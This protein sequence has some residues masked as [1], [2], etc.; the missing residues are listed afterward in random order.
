MRETIIETEA[1][2]R[3]DSAVD[4]VMDAERGF[5][6]FVLAYGQAGRGKS[7][8]ADRYHYTRGGAYVRVWQG[9]SQTAFLQRLLFEVRGTNEDMPRHTGNRCK[10]LIVKLL[11]KKR[12]PLFIDEADRLQIARIEDLRDI[13]EAT[14]VPVV[15]IGEEGIFGLL[16][17]R[18]RIWSRVAHEV[19]FGPIS[20]AEVALYAMQAAGLEIPLALSKEIAQKTEGDFRLVRNAMILLEKSAKASGSFSVDQKMLDAALSAHSWRRK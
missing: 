7:V 4:E 18:R 14:G 17:E 1:M 13:H 19:E 20:P 5:S 9:W 8:A 3:F 6:G 10:E 16:S 2:G 11:E 15:L 12:Q